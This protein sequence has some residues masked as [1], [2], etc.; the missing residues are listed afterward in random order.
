MEKK[1]MSRAEAYD[2]IRRLGLQD[3]CKKKF[4]KN[5]TQCTTNDLVALV[6]SASKK[7]SK[8]APVVETP[9][10]AEPVVEEPVVEPTA[11]VEETNAAPT[12]CNCGCDDVKRVLQ[13]LADALYHNDVIEQETYNGITALINGKE[14]KAPKKLSKNEI[15][16]MFG[17]IKN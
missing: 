7:A 13:A 11:V 10:V 2:E 3:E 1:N 6:Q 9:V 15:D 14:Y 12:H 4:G 5:F 8:S 17:F 16:E